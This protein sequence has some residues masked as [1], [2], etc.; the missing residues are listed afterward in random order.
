[1]KT[2]LLIL[3]EK[4]MEAGHLLRKDKEIL[5]LPTLP[6]II[7][8]Y[9][10]SSWE[11]S[12]RLPTHLKTSQAS[13]SNKPLLIHHFAS[14]WILFCTEN[15][16]PWYQSSLEPQ[17]QHPYCFP[18]NFWRFYELGCFS[19]FCTVGSWGTQASYLCFQT[20]KMLLLSLCPFG[21]RFL[22]EFKHGRK[23]N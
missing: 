7:K 19:G 4:L 5:F 17:K 9:L 6:L 11:Y 15:K 14:R 23:L 8:L 16:E 22:L 2:P 18:E 10:V 20:S 3:E 13:Y 1:M 12:T 21:F